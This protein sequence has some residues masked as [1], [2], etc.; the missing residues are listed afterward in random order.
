RGR[1]GESL[2]RVQHA[3]PLSR[4]TTSSTEALRKYTRAVRLTVMGRDTEALRLAE[5]AAILDSDFANAYVRIAINLQNLNIRAADADSANAHA[6]RL[7]DR[8]PE[9]QRD[10]LIGNY[11]GN[12][13]GRDRARGIDAWQRNIDRGEYGG[14]NSLGSRLETRREFARAE[15][16]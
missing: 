8:L 14:T 16:L 7:R 11:F 12:G 10:G 15:S 6:Y 13:P 4:V 5:E 3:T 1:V 2:R 9:A